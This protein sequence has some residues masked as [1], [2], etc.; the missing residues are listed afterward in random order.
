MSEGHLAKKR[1]PAY[2]FGTA[3]RSKWETSF[4]NRLCMAEPIGLEIKHMTMPG[5]VYQ[6]PPTCSFL[7][8]TK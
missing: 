5:S 8:A 2:I 7:N 3:S 4:T 1:A 6:W